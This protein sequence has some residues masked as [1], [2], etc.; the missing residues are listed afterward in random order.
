MKKRLQKV[1]NFH[2]LEFVNKLNSREGNVQMCTQNMDHFRLRN[3]GPSL[4]S[5]APESS[6]KCSSTVQCPHFLFSAPPKLW[7]NN[8][9]IENASKFDPQKCFYVC[10][11]AANDI[12][13]Y[14][15]ERL[16]ARNCDDFYGCSELIH[17]FIHKF[18]TLFFSVKFL[19]HSEAFGRWKTERILLKMFRNLLCFLNIFCN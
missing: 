13:V 5:S 14:A 8:Q 12:T 15:L 18:A 4:A 10:K 3:H 1:I 11:L 6:Q 9:N 7:K 17:K 2:G 19:A 16:Q